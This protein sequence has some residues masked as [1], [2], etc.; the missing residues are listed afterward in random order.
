M[1]LFDKFVKVFHNIFNIRRTE[2][3]FEDIYWNLFE[4]SDSTIQKDLNQDFHLNQVITGEKIFCKFEHVPLT[5]GANVNDTFKESAIGDILQIPGYKQVWTDPRTPR[6]FTPLPSKMIASA[7]YL[8]GTK[9]I[10]GLPIKSFSFIRDPRKQE[11]RF[12]IYSG[13]KTKTRTR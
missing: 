10:C 13:S 6:P 8:N 12:K 3:N 1:R 9:I 11:I 2:S 4:R 5:G 7:H